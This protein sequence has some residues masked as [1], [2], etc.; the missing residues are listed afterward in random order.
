MK[1]LRAGKVNIGNE[2]PIWD[3]A[4]KVVLAYTKARN[5]ACIL[6]T[7][8]LR[9]NESQGGLDEGEKG[10]IKALDS[11]PSCEGWRGVDLL[12]LWP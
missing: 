11:T 5:D 3:L 7:S 8:W 10:L 12:Y 2:S 6:D 1:I 4:E 9:E